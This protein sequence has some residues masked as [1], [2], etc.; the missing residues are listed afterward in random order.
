MRVQG[1]SPSGR[2]GVEPPGRA[3]QRAH[4]DAP[5]SRVAAREDV[6]QKPARGV[7]GVRGHEVHHR[8][9]G[10]GAMAVLAEGGDQ[11]QGF[12]AR[13]GQTLFH[14]LGHGPASERLGGRAHG[15][16][17]LLTAKDARG[18]AREE[19]GRVE[20]QRRGV[21]Q[22]GL[23]PR[24]LGQGVLVRDEGQERREA[25]GPGQILGG[26]ARVL[27]GP[28]GLQI[29]QGAAAGRVH[30]AAV[31]LEKRLPAGGEVR[32]VE[33]SPLGQRLQEHEHLV[34]VVG[35]IAQALGFVIGIRQRRGR[36]GEIRKFACDALLVVYPVR[37]E[38]QAV[39]HEGRDH[40]VASGVAHDSSLPVQ[41]ASRQSRTKPGR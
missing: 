7:V 14:Q 5:A 24:G 18:G 1:C 25:R 36:G 20:H 21:G 17:R 39:G 29:L 8:G 4:G 30:V 35:E 31:G 38:R 19:L 23:L 13:G 16:N 12:A 37:T 26:A 10:A 15:R 27:E 6:L 41:R 32:A 2:E 22:A 9:Q 3:K 40:G 33:A 34:A 28:T 11:G